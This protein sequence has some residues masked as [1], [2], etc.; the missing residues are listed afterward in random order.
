[1]QSWIT[2]V[3]DRNVMC[4]AAFPYSTIRYTL[5]P[6]SRVFRPRDLRFRFC[7]CKI[8]RSYYPL[9]TFS[10]R[11]CATHN[12]VIQNSGLSDKT[13]RP[14]VRAGG[15]YVVWYVT[16]S[17]R[18]IGLQ[19]KFQC[20]HS[21]VSTLGVPTWDTCTPRL[22]VLLP[23]WRGTFKVSNKREIVYIFLN[24]HKSVNIIFKNHC[25]LIVKYNET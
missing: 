24:V 8:R 19:L 21:L 5:V 12:S 2:L 3:F 25:M 23:I 10:T 7:S 11:G 14:K 16:N 4:S 15:N 20:A 6:F 18:L 17:L 9:V 22:G 13:W 1:V